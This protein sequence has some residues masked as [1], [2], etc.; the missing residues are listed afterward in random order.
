MSAKSK[1]PKKLIFRFLRFSL[2]YLDILIVVEIIVEGWNESSF[3]DDWIITWDFP[4]TAGEL[5]L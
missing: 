3:F 4:D 5:R 2:L 1:L